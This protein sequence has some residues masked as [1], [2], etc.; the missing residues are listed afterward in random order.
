MRR[1][2]LVILLLLT[3]LFTVRT[4]GLSGSHQAVKV[5][6]KVLS[7]PLDTSPLKSG[8]IIMRRG[9]GV[10]SDMLAVSSVHDKRFSHAGILQPVGSTW[11]VVHMIGGEGVKQDG[12]RF[13]RVQDFISEANASDWA[14]YRLTDSD[15]IRQ[16]LQ[17]E[18]DRLRQT[19][20][21]FDSRFSWETDDSYYCTELVSKAYSRASQGRI[22]LPLTYF[23]GI[24]YVSCENLYNNPFAQSVIR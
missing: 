7:K 13:D 23:Q 20:P 1:A 19:K 24:P 3:L 2:A 17:G 15:S 12:L 14:V 21:A 10:I 5:S 22:S 8:D 4:I 6:T 9:R 16:A 11:F 18:I